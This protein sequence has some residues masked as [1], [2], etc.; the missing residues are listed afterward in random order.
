MFFHSGHFGL[1]P[2][3]LLH[4]A[5]SSDHADLPSLGDI[6]LCYVFNPRLPVLKPLSILSTI[7]QDV[8]H[9]LFCSSDMDFNTAGAG[10]C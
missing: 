7:H 9:R 3:I 2:T 4:T 6:N 1:I 5:S 8:P 10:F